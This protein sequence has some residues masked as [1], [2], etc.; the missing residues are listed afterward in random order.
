MRR[1]S[2]AGLTGQ[3]AMKKEDSPCRFN[4][5]QG[6]SSRPALRCVA[7]RKCPV[8]ITRPGLLE[9]LAERGLL[10]GT[11]LVDGKQERQGGGS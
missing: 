8:T 7:H 3:K 2:A 9:E 4:Y 10:V 11:A 6:P 1:S 5:I